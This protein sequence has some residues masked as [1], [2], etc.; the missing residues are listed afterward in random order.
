MCKEDKL[1]LED[2]RRALNYDPASGIFTWAV[3]RGTAVKAGRRAG[4]VNKAGYRQIRLDGFIYYEHR[5]AWFLTYGVWPSKGI[6]H[7]NRKRGDNRLANL[8]EAS[9]A[10]NAQNKG[11]QSNNTTGFPGVSYLAGPGRRKRYV[12]GVG[13]NGK[14]KRIGYFRTGEEAYEAYVEA[15]KVT[16]EFH[17]GAEQ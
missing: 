15:K 7:I 16:H 10:E 17:P 1:T 14:F 6:D 2:A 9:H 3:D 8:R 11:R 12:A 13:K 5:L 4:T